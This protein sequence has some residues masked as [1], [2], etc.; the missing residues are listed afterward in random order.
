MPNGRNLVVLEGTL[1]ADAEV[2]FTHHGNVKMSF[3]VAVSEKW[4]DKNT[5]QMVEKT[6][7]IKV[8]MWYKDS[9]KVAQ[10]LTKGSKVSLQGKIKTD[11]WDKDDGTKAYFTYVLGDNFTLNFVSSNRDN[12][13]LSPTNPTNSPSSP[14]TQPSAGPSSTPAPGPGAPQSPSAPKPA[15]TVN[16][17]QEFDDDIPF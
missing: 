14:A 17:T 9:P 1:G 15:P 2:T 8:V 4:K 16:Q 13:T 12:A 7:W 6:E 11:T 3:S 5:G 10:Y